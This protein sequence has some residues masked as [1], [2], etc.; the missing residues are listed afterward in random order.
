MDLT[1]FAGI[2]ILFIVGGGIFLGYSGYKMQGSSGAGV[3]AV[4]AIL[5]LWVALGIISLCDF[6]DATPE[7]VFTIMLFTLAPPSIYNL[8]LFSKWKVNKKKEKINEKIQ[9]C[10]KEIKSL[11]K[12]LDYCHTI[13]NLIVLIKNCGGD[14]RGIEN[15][16]EISKANKLNEEIKNKKLEI[17]QLQYELQD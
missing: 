16:E 15:N 4:L 9:Y 6:D 7:T 5:G 2:F 8:S 12:E 3:S 14:L 1:N 11:E 10:E 13:F 17:K